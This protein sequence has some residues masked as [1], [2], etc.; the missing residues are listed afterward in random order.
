MR[1]GSGRSSDALIAFAIPAAF[2]GSCFA[3][4]QL[5]SGLGWAIHLW[6]GAIVL[7]GIIGLVLD[8]AMRA[9]LVVLEARP[10]RSDR[11]A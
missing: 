5:I 7:A 2:Y 6:L 1:F 4:V 11:P 9:H 10:D 3:T 8:E